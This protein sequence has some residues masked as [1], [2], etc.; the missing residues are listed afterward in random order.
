M[1]SFTYRALVPRQSPHYTL[2]TFCAPASE[3]LTFAQIDRAG[4]ASGGALVGFQRPQ[5]ADHIREIRSYLAAD[6]AI[7]PNSVVIAFT[8]GVEIDLLEDGTARVRVDAEPSPPGFV[9]DGQQRLAALSSLPDKVFDVLVSAFLCRTAEDLRKQFILINNTRPLPKQLIY[10]LLP[11]VSGLPHRLSSR[12]TAAALVER[13][14]YD[15]ESSLRGQIRQH[16]NPGG[17]LQDTVLQKLI[18]NSLSDG[19]LREFSTYPDGSDASF[20]L[21]SNYFSAVQD[22]FSDSWANHTPKTSRLLHGAGIVAL[23]YVMEHLHATTGAVAPESFASGLSV[24]RGQTAWTQGFWDFGGERRAWNS[25]QF[26]PRDCALLADHL[27][28]LVK[29]ARS[30]PLLAAPTSGAL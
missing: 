5:V 20:H 7:L 2:F 25:L 17:V 13:L 15:E 16:T 22:V 6:E 21:I 8:S 11:S 14:N 1:L 29:R 26:V 27:L 23:G 10:E 19:A 3:V 4:R 24:L 18:M 28:R 9:V 30:S 12:S